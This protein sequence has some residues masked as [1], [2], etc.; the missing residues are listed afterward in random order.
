MR[1]G[2]NVNSQID[3]LCHTQHQKKAGGQGVQSGRLPEK[4]LAALNKSGGNWLIG[5][6]SEFFAF[7]S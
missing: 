4:R 5:K 1:V 3:L 6:G 7:S 2:R